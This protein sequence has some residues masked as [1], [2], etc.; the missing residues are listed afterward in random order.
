VTKLPRLS[1]D[2]M[3]LFLL[4]AVVLAVAAVVLLL[5]WFND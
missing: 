1:R 3:E 4:L 5:L 2:D